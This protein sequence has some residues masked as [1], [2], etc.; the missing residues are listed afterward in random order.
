MMSTATCHALPI[1][2]LQESAIT[3]TGTTSLSTTSRR[4]KKLATNA[5]D[6]KG[7]VAKEKWTRKRSP[8][9]VVIWKKTLHLNPP[10]KLRVE[11]AWVTIQEFQKVSLSHVPWPPHG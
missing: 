4:I 2:T 5:P 11:L 3:P 1:G 9:M 10:K 8:R 7:L 6:D